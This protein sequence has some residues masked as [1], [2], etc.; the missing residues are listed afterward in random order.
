MPSDF[1][2][3][4]TMPKAL[5]ISGYTDSIISLFFEILK[6]GNVVYMVIFP[7]FCI[8]M[9]GW[10]HSVLYD[11]AKTLTHQIENT[12]KKSTVLS[13][14]MALLMPL[15]AAADTYT[16]LWKQYDIALQKDH[17]KTALEVL[18]QILGRQHANEPMVICLR[19][20]LQQP[21]SNVPYPPTRCSLQSTV[22]AV[23]SRM[24]C[25]VATRCSRQYISRCSEPFTPTTGWA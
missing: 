17:P 22:C 18:S 14:L 21:N 4:T 8:I 2:L 7:Y 19:L 15:T 6:S 10:A 5:C 20:S 12:M 23:A 24:P 13:I 16:S 1:A 9:R 25:R 11:T 3:I